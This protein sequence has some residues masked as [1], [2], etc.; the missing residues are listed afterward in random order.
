M[1]YEIWQRDV[2]NYVMG[3]QNGKV[4][5]KGGF[6]VTDMQQPGHNRGLDLRLL[7]V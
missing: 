1:K 5:T 3:K 7:C 6:F 4:K 2:N